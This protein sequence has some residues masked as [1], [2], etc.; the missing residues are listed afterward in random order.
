MNNKFFKSLLFAILIG[1]VFNACKKETIDNRRELNASFAK[2]TDTTGY[3]LVVKENT[4]TVYKSYDAK[5]HRISLLIQKTD[6]EVLKLDGIIQKSN[7]I[8]INT[9]IVTA[10]TKDKPATY[11]IQ[12]E[13]HKYQLIITYQYSNIDKALEI[14][15]NKRFV[16][17]DMGI[18]IMPEKAYIDTLHKNMDIIYMKKE[19]GEEF[20]YPSAELPDIRLSKEN[21]ENFYKKLGA[22]DK[23]IKKAYTYGKFCAFYLNFKS[24]SIIEVQHCV[25]YSPEHPIGLPNQP[26]WECTYDNYGY[27]TNAFTKKQGKEEFDSYID[28]NYTIEKLDNKTVIIRID[29]KNLSELGTIPTNDKDPYYGSFDWFAWKNLDKDKSLYFAYEVRATRTPKAK[30]KKIGHRLCGDNYTNIL[31]DTE[32]GII[33]Y[34]IDVKAFHYQR[35]ANV[36]YDYSKTQRAIIYLK[37][38]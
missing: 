7:K 22:K 32:T 36:Q 10:K 20:N 9:D 15:K 5:T 16:Y 31:L 33:S 2:D 25:S 8:T 28:F 6:K 37:A 26:P 29:D 35:K 38:E 17:H 13:D 23:A 11:D 4:L 1:A 27:G 12:I 14:L 24:N 19:Y 21:Y 30:D 3:I 34:E 18:T